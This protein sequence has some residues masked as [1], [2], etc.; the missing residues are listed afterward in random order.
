MFDI[1]TKPALQPAN[2]SHKYVQ[3]LILAVEFMFSD[4]INVNIC[5][6]FVI[7]CYKVCPDWQNTCQNSD[8]EDNLVE[9][10]IHS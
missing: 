5:L 7:A 9:W 2:I 4:V 3:W 8:E 10:W 1:G 6:K